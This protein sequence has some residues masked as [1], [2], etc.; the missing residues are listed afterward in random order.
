MILP[1]NRNK[2][3]M[4]IEERRKQI[5][6]HISGL[7]EREACFVAGILHD[8]GKI[9][10]NMSFP[11]DYARMLALSDLKKNTSYL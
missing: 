9:L 11:G 5:Q 7:R 2:T 4:T 10:L 3:I 8:R 1:D 6:N